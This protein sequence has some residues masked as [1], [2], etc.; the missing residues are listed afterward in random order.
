MYLSH[1]LMYIAMIGFPILLYVLPKYAGALRTI[2]LTALATILYANSFGY[3]SLLMAQN[4]EKLIAKEFFDFIN[5][6]CRI[7]ICVDQDF[8]RGI[9]VCDF[10]HVGYLFPLC[11]FDR[12]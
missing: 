10:S 12:V 7:G 6:E 9:R 5:L 1:G 2:N 3:S 11:L 8:P 4:K